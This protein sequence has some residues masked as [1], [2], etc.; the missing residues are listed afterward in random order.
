MSYLKLLVIILAVVISGCQQQ[1][2]TSPIKKASEP[3]KI[4]TP[5]KITKQEDNMKSLSKFP[6]Q[7]TVHYIALE[8]GFYGIITNKGEKLLPLNLDKKYMK[9]GTIISF[10]GSYEKDVMTIQQWG[11]PYRLK[12]VHFISE[13]DSSKN[14][15]I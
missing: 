8:G 4:Q 2:T 9:H 3:T 6:H 14:P 12:N 15:E 7:G 11:K 10:S 1:E 13:G 5:K